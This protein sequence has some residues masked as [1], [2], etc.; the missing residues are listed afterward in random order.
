MGKN[1]LGQFHCCAFES[2]SVCDVCVVLK[3]KEGKKQVLCQKEWEESNSRHGTEK[4]AIW[5]EVKEPEGW[6]GSRDR[7]NFNGLVQFHCCAR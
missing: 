4:T 6:D 5:E 2:D 7:G 3:S 1:G